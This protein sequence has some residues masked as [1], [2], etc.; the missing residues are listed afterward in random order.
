[1]GKK[2]NSVERL[3]FLILLYADSGGYNAKSPAV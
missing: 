2:K 1:M 3:K